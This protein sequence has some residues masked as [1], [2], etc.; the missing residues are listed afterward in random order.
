MSS[1]LTQLSIVQLRFEPRAMEV[2]SLLFAWPGSRVSVV[3][4]Q[5]SVKAH[6]KVGSLCYWIFL[7]PAEGDSISSVFKASP[8]SVCPINSILVDF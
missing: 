8:K 2:Y 3:L 7:L 1:G 6:S 5:E 4:N